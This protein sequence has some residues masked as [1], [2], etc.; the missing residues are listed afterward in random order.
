M[1]RNTSQVRSRLVYLAAAVTGL[2]VLAGCSKGVE[3]T[4]IENQ[5]PVVRLTQ[6]PVTPQNRE[7]YAYRMNW[8][9]YDP[10]GRIDHFVY[11]IDPPNVDLPDSSWTNTTLNEQLFFFKASVPDEPINPIS[12]SSADYHVFAIRAV[13]DQGRQSET[14]FRAFFSV[15]ACPQIVIRSP[16]PSLDEPILTPA[17]TITWG[18]IDP[19]GLTGKPVYYRFRLFS[20]RNGDFPG[21]PD[22]IRFA[23]TPASPNSPGTTDSFRRLYAPTFGPSAHCPTCTRWDSVPGDT[24]QA[25]FTNLIPQEQYLF[26]VTGFDDAGAYDPVWTRLR[27]LL[28]FVVGYAGQKGP[29]IR[30]FNEFFDY[31]YLVPGYFSNPER[32]VLIEVPSDLPVTINWIA[33][34]PPGADMRRY[35]WVMD[36]EDLQDETQRSGPNDWYHWSAYSLNTTSA[37]VGPFT[38]NGEVHRFFIEAEDNNGLKSLGIVRFTVVRGT[39]VGDTLENEGNRYADVLFVK[40]TRYSV[41]R[42]NGTNLITPVGSWPTSAELDSFFFARG[43]FPW[44]K[45]PSGSISRPGIF[46]GYLWDTLGTRGIQTGVVPLSRLSKFKSVIWYTDAGGASLL[47]L[48]T[49]T[50]FPTTSL[51]FM[52]SPGQAS[53]L[54]IY[55]R[56]GGQVWL[57]GGGAAT[58]IMNPWNRGP[59]ETYT[60]PETNGN[61]GELMPGRFMFDFVHWRNGLLLTTAGGA[62]QVV[63]EFNG[64]SA[65]RGWAG[66]PDYS[67]TPFLLQARRV[68]EP[69]DAPP[70]LR[71]GDADW[72][73]TFYF[74]ELI[75]VPTFI[76]EDVNG[77]LPGGEESTLDTL[78]YATGGASGFR[79]PVMTYYHGLDFPAFGQSRAK[80]VFSGFPLWYFSRPQAMQLGDFVL[81]DLFGHVRDASADRSFPIAPTGGAASATSGAANRGGP[82][83]TSATRAAR[84]GRER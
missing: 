71:F 82:G 21:I 32:E 77:A 7:D 84:N 28:Q 11:A 12:A 54:S 65:S 53:T 70:P 74:T 17:T 42:Y 8:V 80:I 18:G 35:R 57:F 61:E 13:D 66:A 81:Q 15:T 67:R 4:F 36:L 44:K 55:A 34:P 63:D 41:D 78:Y 40:D 14:A 59:A 6:A 58:A 45:Y 5:A 25:K 9:G 37:T 2:F 51:R 56:Q 26:V 30:M 19:D 79:R 10:D 73:Q 33:T 72:Y 29:R 3:K 68:A 39:F 52:S 69:T 83:N 75:H 48:P 43:N 62:R 38:V 64:T 27:N 76:R 20:R 16:R 1:N 22:F 49:D 46:H 24:T 23:T 31:E 50:R 47:A 60:D